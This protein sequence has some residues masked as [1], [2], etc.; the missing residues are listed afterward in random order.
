M[1]KRTD[2]PTE[3]KRA[4]VR[5]MR[6]FV[7]ETVIFAMFGSMMYLSDIL[8]EALPNIHLVGMFIVLLTVVFRI[9]ALIPLYIY[10]FLNG[11]FAGFS[12]WWIPYLYVWLPLWAM[13]LLIP[14]RAPVWVLCVF[15]SIIGGIHGIAFGTLYSPL[16]ALMFGL[17]FDGMIAWI[18]AGI[19]FDIIH[20]VGN[21]ASGFLVYP[22]YKLLDRLLKL[23]SN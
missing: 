1:I 19:P 7:F 12:L 21:F 15:P 23:H 18:I 20:A 13:A 10:V 9:K 14:R 3:S 4:D 8:M 5:K 22:L 16:Q 6:N 17:D 11:I 2:S